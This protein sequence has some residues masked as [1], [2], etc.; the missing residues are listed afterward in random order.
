M[1]FFYNI[2]FNACPPSYILVFGHTVSPKGIVTTMPE[3]L[4]ASRGGN[5]TFTCETEAGPNTVY[6]WLYNVSN[7]LCSQLNCSDGII[8]FNATDEGN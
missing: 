6:M 4:T 8:S 3:S 2:N 1:N 5:V 7:N